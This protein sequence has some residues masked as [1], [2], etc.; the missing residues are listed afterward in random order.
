MKFRYGVN[1]Y[2]NK[3][4]LLVRLFFS[5]NLENTFIDQTSRTRIDNLDFNAAMMNSI[6]NSV[7]ADP[8]TPQTAKL[9]PEGLAQMRFFTN[10]VQGIPYF[11][12]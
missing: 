3:D 4:W 5:Q 11:P 10:R 12:F 8:V 2:V 1:K 7:A 6:N 9:I